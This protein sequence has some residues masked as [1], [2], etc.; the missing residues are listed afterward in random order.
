M[1]VRNAREHIEAAEELLQDA[2]DADAEADP[3]DVELL[4]RFADVH[5]QIA[6]ALVALPDSPKET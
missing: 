5:V 3:K 2:K 4:L 1:T 6:R